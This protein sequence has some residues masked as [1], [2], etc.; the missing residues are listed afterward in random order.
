[1]SQRMP[2]WWLVGGDGTCADVVALPRL[3]VPRSLGLLQ[4]R[5]ERV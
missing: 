1:M 3:F 5:T 4:Q 2:L